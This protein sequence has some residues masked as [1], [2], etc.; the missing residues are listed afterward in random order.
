M[1][2]KNNQSY[3]RQD[4]M[5]ATKR[6][7]D[8]SNGLTR[9]SNNG[10][11]KIVNRS[12]RQKINSNIEYVNKMINVL[13]LMTYQS[14]APNNCRIHTLFKC[15]WNTK[16]DYM[17]NHKAIPNKNQTIEIYRV[18]SLTTVLEINK[19]LIIRKFA[20]IQKSRNPLPKNPRIKEESK[21]NI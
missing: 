19:K 20:C 8:H 9:D 2:T 5:T 3:R 10:V 4:H 18:C 11:L 14:T 15:T 17:L 1:H 13:Y 21:R 16:I 12:S 6:N 7:K